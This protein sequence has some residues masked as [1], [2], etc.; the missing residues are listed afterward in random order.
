M[1]PIIDVVVS[2][3][4]DSDT[5]PVGQYRLRIDAITDIKQDK[6]NADFIGLTFTVIE[7]DYVNRK[8]Q[9]P[10]VLLH[11]RSTL[12]KILKASEYKEPKLARTEDLIGLE[13]RAYVG[14][15]AA[16]DER[17]EQNNIRNYIIPGTKK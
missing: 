10:Y 11:E 5:I 14:K 17:P 13:L 6:N 7:G 3:L 15:K 12:K 4:P 8:I 16:T 2:D 1:P 9:E